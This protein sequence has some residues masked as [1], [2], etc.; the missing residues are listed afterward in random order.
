MPGTGVSLPI[1]MALMRAGESAIHAI[2]AL[3][4]TVHSGLILPGAAFHAFEMARRSSMGSVNQWLAQPHI[5]KGTG[6][7]QPGQLQAW[8]RTG[9]LNM[10]SHR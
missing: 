7:L 6:R 5:V 8:A 3:F 4:A 9:R 10:E 2:A 1:F